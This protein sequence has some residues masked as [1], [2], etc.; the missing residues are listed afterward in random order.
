MAES[1][2]DVGYRT[3]TTRCDRA[4]MDLPSVLPPPP[5]LK[6]DIVHMNR[7]LTNG[8]HAAR[9]V[10]NLMYPNLDQIRY[11]QERVW[12]ELVPLLDAILE[13]AS[14]AATRSWCCGITKT[15]ADLFNRLTQCEASAQH[16]FEAR[17]VSLDSRNG[18]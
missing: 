2:S 10:L 5:R 14:D 16:R 13:S 18:C 4:V 9:G 8:Y 7:I 17:S 12:S 1:L 3:L 11:H 6:P 15:V